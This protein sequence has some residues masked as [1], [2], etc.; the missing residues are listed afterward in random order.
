M[1]SLNLPTS[2]PQELNHL[3]SPIAV[4]M[5]TEEN[6]GRARNVCIAFP[7]DRRAQEKHKRCYTFMFVPFIFPQRHG[8]ICN[9]HFF[10]PWVGVFLKDPHPWFRFSMYIYFFG[11]VPPSLRLW[12][13]RRRK[14]LKYTYIP[15]ISLILVPVSYALPAYTIIYFASSLRPA[16]PKIM[17]TSKTEITKVRCIYWQHLWFSVPVFRHLP[18]YPTVAFLPFSTFLHHCST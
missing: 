17:V 1:T 14:L 12:L 6:E 8:V 18:A 10:I 16:L 5:E 4:T 7:S 11:F 9:L 15:A 13:P 2:L 3:L